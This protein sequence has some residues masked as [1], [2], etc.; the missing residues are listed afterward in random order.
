MRRTARLIALASLSLVLTPGVAL[1][2]HRKHLP[3][4][5]Q[6]V[7]NDCEHHNSLQ[8]HYPAAVLEQA[9]ADLP[10]DVKEYSLCANE[11]QNAESQAVGGT[12]SPGTA[13]SAAQQ[14][15][16]KHAAASLAQAQR[17][18]AAP[19]TLGGDRIAAGTVGV[20]GASFLSGLPTP[21]I[22]VLALAAALAA[23]PL[24]RAVQSVVRARRAR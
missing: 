3:P 15:V 8:G 22:V 19:L 13:S 21:I 12:H 14:Q 24:S 10:T 23:I 9:L 16:A 7:I 17:Q 11:I 20:S 5:V 4:A 18:G 1:G 6:Q 2:A